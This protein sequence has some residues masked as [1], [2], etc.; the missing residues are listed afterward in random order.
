M[1]PVANQKEIYI[2]CK[3]C[4]TEIYFNT[5]KKV[6]PC[7]CGTIEVDGCENY[8]RVIGSKED[9]EEIQK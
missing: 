1:N 4:N 7:K 3:K 5:H 6:S 9:Y 8:I 2:K